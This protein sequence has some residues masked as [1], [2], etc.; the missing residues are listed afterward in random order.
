MDAALILQIEQLIQWAAT[1]LLKLKEADGTDAQWA[2]VFRQALTENRP[3]NS[4][5]WDSI[6]ALVDTAVQNALDA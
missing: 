4:D 1:G 3:L 2:P 6:K 5:E